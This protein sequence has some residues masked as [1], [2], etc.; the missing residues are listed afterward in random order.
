MSSNALFLSWS[1]PLAGRER[2][3]MSHF[4]DFKRFL[5]QIQAENRIESFEMVM[6]DGRPGHL[7]G[8]FLIQG[9]RERLNELVNGDDWLDHME[10]AAAHLDGVGP[11]WA[12]TDEL[13]L[14]HVGISAPRVS[15]PFSVAQA[16]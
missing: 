10:R 2:L 15:G 11:V 5:H 6:L 8:F 9:D 12:L 16:S 4:D 3:S 7:N 14:R 13:A 1:R